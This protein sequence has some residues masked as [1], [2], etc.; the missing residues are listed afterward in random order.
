MDKTHTH[1]DIE[2]VLLSSGGGIS[3]L[4][5]CRE[6]TDSENGSVD[7]LSSSYT[8]SRAQRGSVSPRLSDL[9]VTKHLLPAFRHAGRGWVGAGNS[10]QAAKTLGVTASGRE[11]EAS[12]EIQSDC[13]R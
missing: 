7:L 8:G 11:T 1:W 13:V 12:E 2:S 10:S 6:R 5:C 3:A 9:R 4:S